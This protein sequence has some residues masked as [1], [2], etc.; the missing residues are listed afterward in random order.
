MRLEC[1]VYA[2]V[3]HEEHG[4]WG[5][6]AEKERQTRR[7]ELITSMIATPPKSSTCQ[8]ML[9]EYAAKLQGT[10]SDNEGPANRCQELRIRTST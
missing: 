4:V 6:Y 8:A 10:S 3:H 7:R 5:G 2:L 9:A 1:L